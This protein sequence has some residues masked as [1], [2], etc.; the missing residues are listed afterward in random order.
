M[1]LANVSIVGNLVHQP[2]QMHFS[3]GR[4]KTTLVVAVNAFG[5]GNRGGE[6]ADFYRV[7]AWGK[8]GELAGQ[9]LS[10][11]NQVT[12]SGRLIL[13]RW[14]DKQGRN[15]V[16]PIVEANQIAFP[17]RQKTMQFDQQKERESSDYPEPNPITGHLKMSEEE[18]ED[19]GD[20]EREE[21]VDSEEEEDYVERGVKNDFTSPPPQKSAKLKTPR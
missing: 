6:T 5:R 12:A 13:D 14:T 15:R 17:P 21:D 9:Y 18:N 20:A 19:E 11:G 16:T 10:K 3:S 1:S 4:I 8:L 2:E 7:E